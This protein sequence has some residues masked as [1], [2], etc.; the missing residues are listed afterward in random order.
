[1]TATQAPPPEAGPAR[2]S[3]VGREEELGRLDQQLERA[4]AGSGSFVLITGE[5]GIG[6]SALAGEFVRRARLRQPGLTLVRGRCVEQY[7]QGEAYLPFL[8]ALG[9]LLL[10][11]GRDPTAALLRSYAPTR[12]LHLPAMAA[13]LDA[14]E[15]L[16]RQTIGAT[17]ERM[18]REMGDLLEAAAGQTLLLGLMEDVQWADPSTLD[19][20]RH[21]INRI[22]RQR[23]LVVMTL[24]PEELEA[25]RPKQKA[26]VLDLR[27]H[28]HC[29]EVALGPLSQRQVADYLD[30]R[31][32]P[33]AFPPELA[34]QLRLRTDGHPLF[35]ASLAQFLAERGEIRR[36]DSRWVLERAPAAGELQAPESVRSMLRR[37]LEALSEQDRLTLEH[38]S[39]MG[40]D[41]LSNV[42]AE[43]LE[44]DELQ[45]EERL[46]RLGR[47]H[48]LI[49]RAGE[50]ELPDGSL[51]TSY[52][53][54]HALD[55]EVLYEALGARKRAL[56]H[57]QVAQ[58]LAQ[59]HA[60]QAARIAGQ[61]ALHFERGR[62][63]DSAITHLAQAGDNAAAVYASGE[64]RAHYDRALRLAE[65]LPAA[66][67]A[68]RSVALLQRRGAAN[69]ALAHFDL[70]IA[71]YG[72]VLERASA[73]GA[74]ELEC[75]A[76]RGLCNALF[77]SQRIEEM[78]VRAAQAL[79]VAERAGSEVLRIEATLLVAQILQE[80]GQLGECRELLDE[81]V[82]ASRRLG[83]KHSLLASLAYRGCLD[84]W[85]SEFAEA[86]ALLGEGLALASELRDGF[87][88]LI[89]LQFLGL[90]RGNLGRM[91]QALATLGEGLAMGQRNG[92]RF[93]VPGL[94]SHIGWIH[95]ELR[96]VPG[97]VERD[98]EGLR[99]ARENGVAQAEGNAMLNLCLD[100]VQAG[101]VEEANR[102]L[103]ELEAL[104]SGA[105]WFGWFH[106][107]RLDA[108][109]SELAI[110]EGRPDRAVEAAR[111]LLDE[112][113]PKEA[114]TYV[115]TARQ[116]L[117]EAACSRG[118][119][120]EAES[121]L[122]TALDLVARHPAPLAEWKLRA[123]LGRLRAA[124]G[125]GQAARREF[126][127][128]AA[129]VRRIADG[130]EVGPLRAT[131]LAAPAVREVLDGA[132]PEL[133]S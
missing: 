3:F 125:E 94:V 53:F 106:Q 69:L 37:K 61:L 100:Y 115:L 12:C 121:Q 132:G 40:R 88:V 7:G 44:E 103:A 91:S 11:R 120:A 78:A 122:T 60:G 105:G 46:L 15:A 118:D 85:R 81:V 25:E 48:R 92:D 77:F 54:V 119:L 20:A 89:C 39:V 64:A 76:L 86:E 4:L 13:S 112:A 113:T 126:A 93:W 110:R 63:F 23:M 83:H 38:A 34:A 32:S 133:P 123:A 65:K 114:W 33:H 107:L 67:Q 8:D 26:F 96:D 41:F 27:V 62:D 127:A 87:V 111:R 14:Q 55:Q 17:K 57:R 19:L 30:A 71:D 10:G 99:S 73:L 36:A 117:A 97:A 75:A 58:R 16:R 6:K 59:H 22:A 95:R 45:L 21:L 31:F 101:R 72:R 124:A 116:V 2:E 130:V 109:R 79:G 18:L 52:R 68:A 98:L 84:Y 47:A 5:A 24:R 128:A 82:S 28:E 35:V 129:I 74:A 51:A 43:L 90:A 50:D 66:E 70:A 29:Q 104:C 49:E 42:L 108:V 56:L 1:V 131:F 80:Q 102:L 9:T